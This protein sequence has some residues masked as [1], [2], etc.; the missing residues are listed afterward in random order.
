MSKKTVGLAFGA[1][2]FAGNI[3]LAFMTVYRILQAM[4]SNDMDVSSPQNVV[5]EIKTITVAMKFYQELFK[6]VQENNPEILDDERF[7]QFAH[8]L[9]FIQITKDM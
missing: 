1:G 9:K 2:W 4:Q 6:Y 7:Q 3:S 8:D 5:A